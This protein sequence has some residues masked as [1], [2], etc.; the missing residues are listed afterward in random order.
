M[1]RD[2]LPREILSANI[3]LEDD[4]YPFITAIHVIMQGRRIDP[5]KEGM[6]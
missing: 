1:R 6:K 5:Y 2:S 3:S 4:R